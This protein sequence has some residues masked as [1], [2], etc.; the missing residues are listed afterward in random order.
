MPSAAFVC[1][2]TNALEVVVVSQ[3]SPCGQEVLERSLSI[4]IYRHMPI[5]AS[6]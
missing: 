1:H 6:S 5:A 4:D 3:E 2:V